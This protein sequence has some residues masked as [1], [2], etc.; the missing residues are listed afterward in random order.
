MSENHVFCSVA[1]VYRGVSRSVHWKQD[2]AGSRLDRCVLDKPVQH[3]KTLCKDATFVTVGI[4]VAPASF[5]QAS[6]IR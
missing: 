5:V 2:K 4:G 6:N 1:R 3:D